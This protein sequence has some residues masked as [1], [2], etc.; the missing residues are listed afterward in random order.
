MGE[1]SLSMQVRYLLLILCVVVA[2]S[3]EGG[4]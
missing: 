3:D 1:I 4:Q 2:Y